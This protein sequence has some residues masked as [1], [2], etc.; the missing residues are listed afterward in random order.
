MNKFITHLKSKKGQ[1]T[2]EYALVVAAIV[3]VVTLVLFGNGAFKTAV[4][5]AFTRATTSIDNAK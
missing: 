1:G 4:T 5:G 3:I 2:V